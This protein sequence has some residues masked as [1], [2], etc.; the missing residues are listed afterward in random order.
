MTEEQYAQHL[1]SMSLA[2][3]GTE[4]LCQWPNISPHAYPYVRAMQE[5]GGGERV[6]FAE[7][8]FLW[9]DAEDIV[10]RFLVNARGWRG[11][12]ARDIKASLRRRLG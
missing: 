11:T 10:L 7:L 1:D 3:I 8:M 12:T 9:D 6:D 5:M 4:I 2:E